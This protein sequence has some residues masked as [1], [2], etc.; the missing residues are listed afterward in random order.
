MNLA[1]VTD[2]ERSVLGNLTTG[3]GGQLWLKGLSKIQFLFL[4]FF[5]K[6]RFILRFLEAMGEGFVCLFSLAGLFSTL[7][8]EYFSWGAS[9]ALD[10]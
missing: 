10:N 5:F 4:F 6:D 2:G 7:Q 9:L 8:I 1:V 3:C